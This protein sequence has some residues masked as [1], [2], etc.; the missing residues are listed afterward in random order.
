MIR[1][2]N[3][4]PTTPTSATNPDSTARRRFLQTGA[5]L[6]G[7][8][9]LELHANGIGI[10]R[11]DAAPPAR[12]FTP[13]AWVRIAPDGEIWLVS[14]K[15]DSGTGVKNAL[16][17]ILA[18]ELDADW[19]QVKVIAPDDP[20]AKAYIHPL[21]GM[22][23]TGGSTSVSLEWDKLRHAGAT[24]RAML[25]AE[26]AQRWDVAP[27]T[28]TA[29]NSRVSHPPSGRSISYGDLAEGAAG[30]PVP[31]NVALKDPKN[32]VLVGKPRPSYRVVDKITGR[33][34][35]AIDVKL[36]GMLTA[37]V[38][39]PPVVNAKVVSFNAADV[40]AMPG[41]HEVFALEIPDTIAHFRP[42]RPPSTVDNGACQAGVT[43][44]AENFWS[45]QRAR[46]ALTVEWSDS[47]MARFNSDDAI[48]E[49]KAHA[50]DAG[51]KSK[52]KGDA[53]GALQS[54][55]NRVVEAT[56]T[57]PYKAH[58][59]MEPL[60]VV[61]WVKPDEVEYWGGIQVPS[62]CAQAAE[63]VA[64]VPRTRVRI[65]LTE[66]GGSFGAREGLHQI[67]EATFISKRVGKPV[68]L[69]YSREDDIQALFYHAATVHKARA[70]LDASGQIQAMSLRAVVPS[71]KAPDDPG[72]LAKFPVDPSCTEGMRD[73]FYYDLSAL[74]L[75]WVRHEPGFPIWWWRAV[76]YV[77]N[78]FAIESIVDEA[79][80][81]AKQDPVAYRLAMLQSRPGLQAVLERAATLSGW[82]KRKPKGHGLGVAVYE[83]YK[84]YIAIVAD[85][86][87]HGSDIAVEH[88]TC[89]VDCG[90]AVDP[91]SVRQQ[92][93]GGIHWGVSTA[94]FNEVHI[95]NGAVQESNFHNYRVV[96][97][98]EAPKVTI[99][100][101]PSGRAPAGVGELSNPPVVPAI[102]N[103][104]FAATGHRLRATPFTL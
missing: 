26:A 81:A 37:I 75:A 36:P 100:L 57:M 76:S 52:T 49:M 13:N 11:A 69:L 78:I 66:A 18:E 82:G 8:M 24:A 25:V 40:K 35:Y 94:L 10:V 97:I 19:S 77:P 104:I 93:A 3:A 71:I 89:V 90:I 54:R 16:G 33:A 98:N 86:R 68:K 1:H 22:H 102:G 59:Q 51:L 80:H 79:S 39:H 30:Q 41:V 21:W 101:M 64:G 56:Y 43:I 9:L 27:A 91:D 85:V 38:V 103:A 95:K 67:L 87:V 7:G 31:T 47:A 73:D 53:A 60:S 6:F 12:D 5:A 55:A 42:D 84:S 48:T 61:A 99:D 58:A 74:D 44:V 17:L 63:T 20:L 65:H 4:L 83:G 70:A 62:R 23:A 50:D 45:A 92:L 14:H 15:F 28:C 29:S 88:V 72:F 34:E 32:F 46:K 96:R 2:P